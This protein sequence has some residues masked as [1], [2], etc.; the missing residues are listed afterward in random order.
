[1]S[2][3]GTTRTILVVEDEWLLLDELARAFRDDGWVVL[4][5]ATGEAALALA[6]E[7]H[8][9]ALLTDIQLGGC[10]SGWDVAETVRTAHPAT[11]VVHISGSAA[12]HS[13][14]VPASHFFRKPYRAA[15]ILAACSGHG[16]APGP[17]RPA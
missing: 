10:V 16:N 13:R 14:Q 6:R 7:S 12:D 1:V 4:E 9:D 5:A 15:A 17:G 8:I 3:Q 2:P 11:E